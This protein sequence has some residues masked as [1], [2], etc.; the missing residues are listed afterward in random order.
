MLKMMYKLQ[1]LLLLLVL[2]TVYSQTCTNTYGT[3]RSGVCKGVDECTGAALRGNCSDSRQICCIN[4]KTIEMGE[5]K[6]LTKEILLKLVGNT[7]RTS[8]IY[9]YVVE[10]MRYASISGKYEEQ[11]I[12]AYLSQLVGETQFFRRL[13]SD[14]LDGDDKDSDDKSN[15]LGRGAIFIRGRN[16]YVAANKSTKYGY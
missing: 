5:H 2:G 9:D 14:K 12:A 7:T 8:W 6:K 13:E 11:K 10:S 1:P 16:N 3:K 4:D 15:Y